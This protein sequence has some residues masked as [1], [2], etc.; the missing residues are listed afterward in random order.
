[1]IKTYYTYHGELHISVKINK[2]TIPIVF[3]TDTDKNT[4]TGYYTTS[5]K[6][7]QKALENRKD[8]GKKIKLYSQQAEAVE[9]EPIIELTPIEG[10]SN[11]QEAASYL[12]DKFSISGL[13][14][15]GYQSVIKQAEEHGIYFPD[16][17]EYESE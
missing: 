5:N 13:F 12:K 14:L 2:N 7:I 16:L 4:N 11:W 10:I 6:E 1:M 9:N 15:R 17:K 8:F 3:R